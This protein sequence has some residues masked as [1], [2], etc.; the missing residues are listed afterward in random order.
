MK[1]RLLDISADDVRAIRRLCALEPFQQPAMVYE[2][3]RPTGETR[4]DWARSRFARDV[5]RLQEILR[6]VVPEM[7]AAG[8]IEHA[9]NDEWK[10]R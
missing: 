6:K 9:A 7:V 4:A 2:F 1:E 10:Q 3:H 8:E 5:R